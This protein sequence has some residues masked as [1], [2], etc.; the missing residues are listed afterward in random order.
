M[1]KIR[2]YLKN[3]IMKIEMCERMFDASFFRGNSVRI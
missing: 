2:F 1:G 3:V